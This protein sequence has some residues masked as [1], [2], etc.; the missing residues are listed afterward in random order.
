MKAIIKKTGLEVFIREDYTPHQS[1]KGMI[2][3]SK[4]KDGNC[5]FSVNKEYLEYLK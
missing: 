4:L 2:C 5:I 1:N 3:V